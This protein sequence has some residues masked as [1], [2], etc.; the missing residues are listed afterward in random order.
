MS[1]KERKPVRTRLLKLALDVANPDYDGRRRH[2]HKSV[3][4]YAAGA[5]IRATDWEM[6]FE[7]SEGVW[8]KLASTTYEDPNRSGWFSN[9][10][11]EMIAAQDTGTEHKPVGIEDLASL[12]NMP[13]QYICESA[14]R[15]LLA[16]G[17][18]TLDDVA[19]AFHA[20]E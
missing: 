4:V 14:I 20:A 18:L 13:V 11:N 1:I 7:V 8:D 17:K 10:L 12:E 5:A 15:H 3:K 19:A 16:S 2:G 9:E 6:E